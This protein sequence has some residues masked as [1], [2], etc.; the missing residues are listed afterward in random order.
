MEDEHLVL[1]STPMCTQIH[2]LSFHLHN[3]IIISIFGEINNWHSHCYDYGFLAM[4]D[5]KIIFP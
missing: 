5:T 4:W 3:M 1:L 2:T